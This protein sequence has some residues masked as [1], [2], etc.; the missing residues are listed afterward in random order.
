MA[1]SPDVAPFLELRP[2]WQVRS[3][4]KSLFHYYDQ[5]GRYSLV[6]ARIVFE[7]GLRAYFAQRFEKVDNSGDPETVDEYYIERRGHWRIGKQYLPFGRREILHSTAPAI[8]VDTHV[9]VED[10]AV[11]L[12]VCDGGS[13]RT[14]GAIGRIGDRYGLSFAFGDHFGIQPTDLAPFKDIEN[15]PG[16]GRGYRMALGVDAETQLGSTILGGE[17]VTF[18]RGATVAD[19]DKGVS[20][21][22]V[23]FWVPGKP[24]RGTV[25]WSRDWTERRD[26]TVLELELKADDHFTYVPRIRM[27][28]MSFKDFSLSAVVRF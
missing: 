13:G 7:T 18:Q 28:G 1:Q 23:R 4:K 5:S 8:R 2:T 21:L 24:Y 17:Y 20:D 25:A 3:V 19:Q 16:A 10:A 12:A 11:T 6:G 14:R 26:F 27:E 9:L 15:G 22:R